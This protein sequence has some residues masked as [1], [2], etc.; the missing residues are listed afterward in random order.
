MKI[1]IFAAL[2]ALPTL[3]LA[4]SHDLAT[5]VGEYDLD[6][7]G[8]A[9]ME[10][11]QKERERRFAAADTNHNS[12]ISQAEYADEYRAR[13]M[14]GKPEAAVIEKQMKQ[15]DVRFNVLDANKDGHISSAE[16]QRSGWNMFNEHDYNRDGAVSMADKTDDKSGATAAS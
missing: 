10:E 1:S 11:F 12:G 4:A 8:S 3:S 6:Q 13:L 14:L 16:F 7:N 15:T 5:F 2:L 9:S